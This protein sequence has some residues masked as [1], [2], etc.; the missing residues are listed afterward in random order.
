MMRHNNLAKEANKFRTATQ[1]DLP[2]D[3]TRLLKIYSGVLVMPSWGGCV[4]KK[5]ELDDR[6][7]D[8]RPIQ[9]LCQGLPHL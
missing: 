7:L 6:V 3:T 2:A 5:F 9:R 4:M 1:A 8:P